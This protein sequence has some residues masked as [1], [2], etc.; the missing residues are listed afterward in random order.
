MPVRDRDGI[1]V[2]AMSV[3]MPTPRYSRKVAADARRALGE[4]VAAA[5]ERL[6]SWRE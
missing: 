2:A 5:S 3:S 6:G 1:T 4:T